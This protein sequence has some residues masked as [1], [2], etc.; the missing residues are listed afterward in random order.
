[1]I[2]KKPP[3]FMRGFWVGYGTDFEPVY[4]G[5]AE[6]S[7]NLETFMVRISNQFIVLIRKFH[8]RIYFF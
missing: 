2:T 1:M 5:F 3:I 4:S 7:T 8:I 6:D